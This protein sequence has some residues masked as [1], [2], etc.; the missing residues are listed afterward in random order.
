MFNSHRDGGVGGHHRKA[1]GT[2]RA[3]KR[4]VHGHFSDWGGGTNLGVVPIMASVLIGRLEGSAKGR[5]IWNRHKSRRALDG[6]LSQSSFNVLRL[7]SGFRT[8]KTG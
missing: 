2:Q 5:R 4:D 3:A 8:P 7:L 1:P 6:I